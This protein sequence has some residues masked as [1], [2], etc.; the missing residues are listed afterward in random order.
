MRKLIV[1]AFVSVD[2]VMQGP[3][4]PTEDTSGGFRLGG[5]TVP[6]FD[7]TAGQ[8]MDTLFANP[9]DLLLGRKTYDIFAAY[10]PNAGPDSAIGTLFDR[11]NKYVATRN[12][13]IALGWQNSHV[14]QPDAVTAVKALKA[15]DGPDL[16]TQGSADFLQTL[17]ANDLVD[18]LNTL[19]F[20]LILGTGKRL[21]TDGA[22]PRAL[23]LKSSTASPSGVTVNRY[24]RAGEVQ[25]RSF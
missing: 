15:G 13:D 25:T 8:T 7:E 14:L 1:T 9:F 24:V 19:T 5:W 17:F 18:E 21:F 11:I 6:Y 2:G 12:P 10:W 23:H 3:G 16:M 4:G 22:A 20:P